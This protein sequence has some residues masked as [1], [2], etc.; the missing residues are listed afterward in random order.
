MRVNCATLARLFNV[1]KTSIKRY[2]DAG[3]IQLDANGLAC[4]KQA[5][6]SVLE[7]ATSNRVKA[8][9]FKT[10]INT[11]SAI[12]AENDLLRKKL[13]DA[14]TKLI[15]LESALTETT[16]ALD[17]WVSDYWKKDSDLDKFL[18]CLT[19]DN[20]LTNAVTNGD[21]DF[22]A[23][24][25]DDLIFNDFDETPP[26]PPP[27]PPPPK[28]QHETENENLDLDD[29]PLDAEFCDADFLDNLTT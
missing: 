26:P 13:H 16:A 5:A 4:P 17:E 1:S 3:K 11:R 24:Y 15:E 18:K 6:Q 8:K 25:L 12:E 23:D 22:I 19:T 7:S 2:V 14:Q 10:E 21:N 20:D 28:E 9:F 27:P 29:L